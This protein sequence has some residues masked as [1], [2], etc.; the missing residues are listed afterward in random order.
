MRRAEPARS[1]RP[2]QGFTLLEILL[3]LFVFSLLI[4][5]IFAVVSGTT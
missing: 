4:T 2:P 5:S 3:A 1:V